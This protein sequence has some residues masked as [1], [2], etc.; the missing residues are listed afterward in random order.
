MK[1]Q[2]LCKTEFCLASRVSSWEPTRPP[3][4][5]IPYL[6]LAL[7]LSVAGTTARAAQSYEPYFFSTFA[8]DAGYGSADGTGSA[9]RFNAPTGVAVNSAGNVYVADTNN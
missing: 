9:A 2:P 7:M 6:F 3:M 8:G 5:L 4:K 1:Q